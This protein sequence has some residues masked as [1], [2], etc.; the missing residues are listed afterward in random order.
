MILRLVSRI[1]KTH[2]GSHGEH[3]F[4]FFDELTDG[5]LIRF[6]EKLRMKK[7]KHAALKQQ[8][9][10]EVEAISES[11]CDQALIQ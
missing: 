10:S 9:R 3:Y 2:Y 1:F 7:E 11:Q 8:I 6:R 5:Q 4:L